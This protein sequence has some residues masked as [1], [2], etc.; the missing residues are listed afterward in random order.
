M[1]QDVHLVKTEDVHASGRFASVWVDDVGAC[2]EAVGGLTSLPVE[3]LLG[4]TH[5]FCTCTA[6]R[7]HDL[8]HSA[9]HAAFQAAARSS[10]F[11]IFAHL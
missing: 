9:T 4:Q 3:R 8:K 6:A 1:W 11:A 2:H 7:A 5:T 10:S